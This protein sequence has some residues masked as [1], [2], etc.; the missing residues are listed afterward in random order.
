[1]AYASF[2]DVKPIIGEDPFATT[3]QD[4]VAAYDSTKAVPQMIFLGVDEKADG[5]EYQGK[6]LY[7]GAP[8]FALDVTTQQDLIK[9]VEGRGLSFAKGRV[10]DLEAGDG[11]C[12]V[13][14]C[15][16]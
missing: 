15:A 13:S 2:E 3:E 7:K 1:M 8:Y 11:E 4:M 10:M 5:L 16:G 9:K 6:N 14:W 12:D